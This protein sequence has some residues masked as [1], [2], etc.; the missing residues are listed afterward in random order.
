M[1]VTGAHGGDEVETGLYR[2]RFTWWPPRAEDD[3]DPTEA[4]AG[5]R[6]DPAS[7]RVPARST[8]PS[9]VIVPASGRGTFRVRY[10]TIHGYRR[11]YVKAGSGPVLLL[12]HGI[13]DSSDTWRPVV[14]HLAEHYTV[15]APDLLGHGRSEKPKADYSVAGFADGLRDLLTVLEW[16]GP[17]GRAPSGGW[18][19]RRI[20]VPV[21]RTLRT[22]GAG[23]ER[24]SG[25]DGQP[26]PPCGRRPRCRSRHAA[27]RPARRS[28]S[29][30]VWAP[31]CCGCSTPRWRDAEELLAVFDALPNTEART[32]SS[33]PSLE[34]R[35]AWTGH[36][37]A[38]PCLSGRRRPAHHLGSRMS[39]IIPLG[40]G[41]LIHAVVPVSAS[42]SSTTPDISA[43][44]RSGTLRAGPPRVHGALQAGELR[45]A[46]WRQRRGRASGSTS[47]PTAGVR[48][49][50]MVTDSRVAAL[51]K[52]AAALTDP[53][54]FR[55]R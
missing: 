28:A 21:P 22:P 10:V 4:P 2:L 34:H 44:H 23:G 50:A 20:Y 19:R 40:H 43:P 52:L 39:A 53:D 32:G 46:T 33:D 48:G 54:L 16:I 47:S 31:G 12:I 17:G 24:G 41:R 45:P 42:W 29:R 13:G 35:L 7:K 11:A 18:G 38:R 15:I 5:I 25:P 55:P 3:A 9:I 51:L 37:H 30:A 49:P 14:G 6:N 36:H 8:P 26:P 1:G 27:A